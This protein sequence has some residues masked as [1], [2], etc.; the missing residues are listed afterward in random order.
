MTLQVCQMNKKLNIAIDGLS[1]SGKSTL[2][3]KLSEHYNIIYLDTGALYRTVGLRIQQLDI[4]YEDTE[5]IIKALPDV[6]ISLNLNGVRAEI[7]LC[8]K[9][10]GDEIRTPVSS[11]YASAISKIPEVRHFLFETQRRLATEY[12]CVMDGRDIGT[13]IMPN[14]DVKLYLKANNE[15]R[16]ARRYN[17]LKEKGVQV[18]LDEIR[19]A[20]AKRDENDSKREI[21]PADAIA[22]DAVVIDN[23]DITVDEMVAMAIRIIDEAVTT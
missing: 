10:V 2:A 22:P 13:I 5:N 18:A 7:L 9:P 8:G 3:K 14:A 16:A 19:D 1:G 4:S 21:A 11:M 20:M 6:D 12:S 23:S 17:E 15:K